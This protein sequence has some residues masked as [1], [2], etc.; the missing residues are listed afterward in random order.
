MKLKLSKQIIENIQLSHE[1]IMVYIGII[2]SYKCECNAVLTNKN[3]LN[4]YL[5]QTRKIP[6]RF[7]E[8]LRKGLQE[9]LDKN[10]VI[11]KEKVGIDYYFDFKNI[12][13]DDNDKFVFVDFEDVRKIM[14]SDFQN[15]GGLLRLYLCMLSTFISS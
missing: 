3:M 14:I 9:L 12:K 5:T 1:A 15:K 2:I 7:E 10:I 13:L 4:Y 8:N 6:R 11:C